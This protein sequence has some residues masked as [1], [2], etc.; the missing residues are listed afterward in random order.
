MKAGYNK[1][2]IAAVFGVHSS[3]LNRKSRRHCGLKD[4]GLK[5]TVQLAIIRRQAK[6]WPYITSD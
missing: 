4:Y 3:K 5:Q 6:G 2:E 1:A